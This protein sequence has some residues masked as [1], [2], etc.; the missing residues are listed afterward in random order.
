VAVYLVV[1]STTDDKRAKQKRSTGHQVPNR[2]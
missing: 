1:K 2:S